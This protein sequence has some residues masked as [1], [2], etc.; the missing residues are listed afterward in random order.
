M[1]GLA[2]MA[3][4]AVATPPQLP[5]YPV[6]IQTDKSAYTLKDHITLTLVNRSDKPVKIRPLLD[7]DRS[8][9]DGTWTDVYKL[10]AT[11]ECPATEAEKTDECVTI[12]AG[13]KLQMVPWNWDNGG[14]DQCPPRR[15][16]HRAKKGVHRIVA[17]WCDGTTP[18]RGVSRVKLV[19]WE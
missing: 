17:H 11:A 18:E 16:G 1:I 13:E 10:R 12:K 15:P 19:T 9:G 4:I 7:V 8:N 2:L 5:V 14:Y 6:I 3:A